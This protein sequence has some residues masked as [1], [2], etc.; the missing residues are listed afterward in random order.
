LRWWRG[1]RYEMTIEDAIDVVLHPD[2]VTSTE[3]GRSNAWRNVQSHWIRVTYI[4][5]RDL[6]VIITITLKPVGP[7]EA[8]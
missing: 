7:T 2:V 8:E 3:K 4:F 5:E 6:H 1:T